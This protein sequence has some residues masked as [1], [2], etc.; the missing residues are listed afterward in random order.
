MTDKNKILEQWFEILTAGGRLSGEKSRAL[1]QRA[2]KD[3]ACTFEFPSERQRREE[4]KRVARA[5]RK[6]RR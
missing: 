1:P 3:P 4:A 2:Y 6:G 5:N